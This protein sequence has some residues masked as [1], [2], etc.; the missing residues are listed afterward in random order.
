MRTRAVLL[1]LPLLLVACG[2]DDDAGDDAADTTT[3]TTAA[4]DVADETTTTEAE[5]TTTEALPEPLTILVSNDDGYAAEG[6]DALVE[7]LSADSTLEVIVSAPADEQS[8]SGDATTPGPLTATEVTT[9]SGH[10]AYAVQGEPADSVIY[11]LDTVLAGDPPDLVISGINHGQNIGPA[12]EL[13]GTVGAART[14]ARRGIPALA[15]SQGLPGEGVEFDFAASVDAVLTWLDA[16]RD[17]LA[18]GSFVNINVPTCD[19]GTELRG[20]LEVTTDPTTDLGLA[21]QVADCGST[22]APGDVPTD[23]TAFNA[24]FAVVTEPG[25][26]EG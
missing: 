6:I 23:V 22:L 24:G 13:S 10:P 4:D 25:L 16:N 19:A 14:A 1:A 8:G 21:V 26:G 18:D 20:T 2:G 11:G 3:A 7:A 17:S 15:I 12:V 9:L 5:T